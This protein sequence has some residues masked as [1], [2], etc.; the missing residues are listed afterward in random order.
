ME[1]QLIAQK[2]NLVKKLPEIKTALSA[3]NMLRQ[4]KEEDESVDVSFKLSD[5]VHANAVIPNEGETVFLWLG[6]NVMLEYSYDEAHELL[7]KNMSNSKVKLESL[8]TDLTFLQ[9]QITVEQV[10]FARVHNFRV[11]LRKA[12]N[13]TAKK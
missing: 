5:S 9:E 13:A 12:Q 2:K 3:L 6:A 1:S 10:N 7:E 8:N 11:S 4:K